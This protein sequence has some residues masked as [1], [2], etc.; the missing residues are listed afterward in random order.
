MFCGEVEEEV[1]KEALDFNAV[2]SGHSLGIGGSHSQSAS[3]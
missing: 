1:G 3:H 2:F